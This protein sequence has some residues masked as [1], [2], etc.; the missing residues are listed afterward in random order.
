M[1][2][3]PLPC[4]SAPQF[5]PTVACGIPLGPKVRNPAL[6]LQQKEFLF[7]LSWVLKGFMTIFRWCTTKTHNF[8]SKK[9]QGRRERKNSLWQLR[10]FSLHLRF[11]CNLLISVMMFFMLHWM[12]HRKE[13]TTLGRL[14]AFSIGLWLRHIFHLH[15]L[16]HF[17]QSTK[18]HSSP[19]GQPRD[20][21][22]RV[23]T[24]L[25]HV[26]PKL[27]QKCLLVPRQKVAEFTKCAWRREWLKIPISRGHMNKRQEFEIFFAQSRQI[28]FL[29]K[30]WSPN[31]F[32][33]HES[34]RQFPY[35]AQNFVFQIRLKREICAKAKINAT[36]LRWALSKSSRL[37]AKLC[38]YLVVG[39]LLGKLDD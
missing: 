26:T 22:W 15:K 32:S 23:Q 18:C 2:G 5:I 19:T 37:R 4:E 6:L 13:L 21:I 33:Q 3:W 25:R 27:C 36:A 24:F 9:D 14:F 30:F 38:L 11:P 39:L 35:C 8:P 34:K 16:C 17:T 29:S 1:Y 12:S 31:K 10:I 28:R 20:W 7:T